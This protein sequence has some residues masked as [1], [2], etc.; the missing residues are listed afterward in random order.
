LGTAIFKKNSFATLKDYLFKSIKVFF[1]VVI[2]LLFVA[3]IIEG[4]LITLLG[5]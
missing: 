1:F 4:F 5:G 2:P 3:A